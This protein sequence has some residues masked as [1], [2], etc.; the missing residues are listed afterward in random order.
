MRSSPVAR[1]A[2]R[3]AIPLEGNRVLTGQQ[4]VDCIRRQILEN[5][6][7]SLMSLACS[8]TL[9][10]IVGSANRDTHR[11]RIRINSPKFVVVFLAHT[12]ENGLFLAVLNTAQLLLGSMSNAAA[13]LNRNLGT[14]LC[15]ATLSSRPMSTAQSSLFDILG[16]AWM[17]ASLSLGSVGNT[18]PALNH[19]IGTV[20]NRTLASNT[21]AGSTRRQFDSGST[22]W[23]FPRLLY[24]T[25]C[26]AWW[27]W[28]SYRRNVRRRGSH[29]WWWRRRTG[30]RSRVSWCGR[31][32]IAKEHD[33]GSLQNIQTIQE[34]NR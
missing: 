1:N 31:M 33:I 9:L 16:A 25:R 21:L 2:Q 28:Y 20:G 19:S 22:L 6:Q 11:S 34:R 8:L 12:A 29:R 24:L 3:R 18:Q 13:S 7:S 30:R 15:F 10:T 14:S 4:V 17:L 23:G 32:Q 26:T 5:A 27:W